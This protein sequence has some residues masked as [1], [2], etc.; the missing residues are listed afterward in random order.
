[1]GRN[2]VKKVTTTFLTFGINL[3]RI[4][5]SISLLPVVTVFMFFLLIQKCPNNQ[6]PDQT[7]PRSNCQ[8]GDKVWVLTKDLGVPSKR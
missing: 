6:G 7:G 4:A 3:P 5:C 8:P 2:L 1:M